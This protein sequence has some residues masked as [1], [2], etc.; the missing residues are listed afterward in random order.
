MSS[1]TRP[2][3][4]SQEDRTAAATED[5]PRQVQN[6]Q[7]S[8]ARP[9]RIAP[10]HGP[11]RAVVRSAAGARDLHAAL[12]ELALIANARKASRS[13]WIHIP[14]MT[15]SRLRSEWECFLR[16][17]SPEIVPLLS[18]VALTNDGVWTAPPTSSSGDI[19]REARMVG[20]G[21]PIDLT[22]VELDSHLAK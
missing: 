5:Q 14:K 12:L 21:D 11:D 10:L 15:L 7:A 6:K 1:R 19:L 17:I 18:I 16:A 3:D 13:L 9:R 4:G 8:E 20:P 22:A 2:T